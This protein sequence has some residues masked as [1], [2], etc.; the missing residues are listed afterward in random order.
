MR[1]VLALT[2]ILLASPSSAQ[3]QCALGDVG[4]ELLQS[5]GEHLIFQ[6]VTK[7][8]TLLE[9]YASRDRGTWS[10]VEQIN[11]LSCL[12][13]FGESWEPATNSEPEEEI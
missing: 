13:F 5:Y 7:D 3:V 11:G 1:F 6:G 12:M 9:I 4:A 10:V 8:G 2:A